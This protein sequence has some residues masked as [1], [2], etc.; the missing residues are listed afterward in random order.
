M[1][2]FH[3]H[4]QTYMRLDAG[5][6]SGHDDLYDFLTPK[7][8][9]NSRITPDGMQEIVLTPSTQE[10]HMCGEYFGSLLD[11]HRLNSTISE[12]MATHHDTRIVFTIKSSI[13]Q[14]L[15]LIGCYLIMKHGLGFEETYLSFKP[16]HEHLKRY[17]PTC[18][19]TFESW[20][21]S[22]C[23]AKCMGWIDC[24]VTSPYMDSSPVLIDQF[25]HDDRF[26]AHLHY[27][28]KSHGN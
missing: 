23:C 20:L 28:H 11:V 15:F 5:E 7:K 21:R 6:T 4:G 14:G 25:V 18:G 2:V 13:A 19:E 1:Q 24:R 16:F 8:T 22:F 9:Q 3:L 17:A 26:I 12:L 27:V 10:Q